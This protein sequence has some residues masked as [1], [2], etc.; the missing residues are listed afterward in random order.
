MPTTSWF[1]GT[2]FLAAA[3]LLACVDS[4]A[5]T[6]QPLLDTVHTVAAATTGVPVEETFT[7]STAGTYQITLTDFGAQLT[8]AAPLA[9]VKLAI[10]SG[11]TL[12]NL[13]AA[14]GGKRGMQV[15]IT[16]PAGLAGR[17]DAIEKTLEGYLFEHSVRI[18][19][20]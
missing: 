6:S 14:A 19:A 5:Q 1:S 9:S 15:T 8:P 7:I 12:V 3:C 11:S 13:T 17:K 20:D 4:H 18:A 2:S 10:T 16:L